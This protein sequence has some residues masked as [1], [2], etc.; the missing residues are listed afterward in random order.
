MEVKCRVGFF[1][2]EKS[3]EKNKLDFLP[4]SNNYNFATGGS[5]FKNSIVFHLCDAIISRCPGKIPY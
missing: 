4:A 5:H 1:L 3:E 2:V